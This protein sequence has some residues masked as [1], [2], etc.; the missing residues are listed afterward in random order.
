MNTTNVVMRGRLLAA[1]RCRIGG[2]ADREAAGAAYDPACATT[3]G[4]RAPDPLTQFPL[5]C[6]TPDRNT[7]C[8]LLLARSLFSS[9][10]VVRAAMMLP[11]AA[12]RRSS[13][14]RPAW[15]S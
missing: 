10:D 7:S 5:S 12:L 9:T 11:R 3:S 4:L 6:H 2:S 1:W 13:R 14:T 15:I 8:Y